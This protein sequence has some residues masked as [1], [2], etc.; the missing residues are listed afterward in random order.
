MSDPERWAKMK[1]DT[2]ERFIAWSKKARLDCR[3]SNMLLRHV[4]EK[5]EHAEVTDWVDSLEH[6]MANNYP[7]DIDILDLSPNQHGYLLVGRCPNGDAVFIETKDESMPVSYGEY[8]R[9]YS[10]N[11]KGGMRRISD[12]LEEYVR[13]LA[14][15]T[16]PRD[17]WD[18]SE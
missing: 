10:G 7:C 2:F 13:G 5:S 16:V 3:V 6:V 1:S 18:R 14:E 11:L 4:P 17:F 9:L 8:G 15:G 12:S